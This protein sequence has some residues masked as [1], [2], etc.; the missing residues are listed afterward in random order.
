MHKSASIL[1]FLNKMDHTDPE[2]DA[3]FN[4]DT[5]KKKFVFVLFWLRLS[6]KFQKVLKNA[7]RA[8]TIF[9]NNL[10]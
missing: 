8:L 4:S 6:S 5:N 1:T 7:N 9:K 2:M 3:K 10:I